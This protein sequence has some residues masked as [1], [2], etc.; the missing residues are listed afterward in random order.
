LMTLRGVSLHHP[1]LIHV[2][3][4][5]SSMLDEMGQFAGFLM[6]SVQGVPLHLVI[7]DPSWTLWERVEVARQLSRIVA[8]LHGRAVHIGDVS[9]NN[10]LVRRERQTIEA[11]LIDVDSCSLPGFPGSTVTSRYMPPAVHRGEEAFAAGEASDAYA[12]AFLV[13]ELLIGG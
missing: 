3:W 8:A 12:L 1:A 10:V 6:A 5:Q 2:A 7:K 4:P 11:N 13:F 9:P